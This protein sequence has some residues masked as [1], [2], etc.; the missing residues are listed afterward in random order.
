MSKA[1][2]EA[3]Y[4]SDIQAFFFDSGPVTFT[5]DAPT[6]GAD[7]S[8]SEIDYEAEQENEEDDEEN[9]SDDSDDSANNDSNAAWEDED[10]KRL[11]ISLT[12]TNITKK[13]RNDEEED[14]I[15]GAEYTRRLRKQ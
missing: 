5:M 10:D 2:V 9:D 14:V 12:A 1:L 11:K 8:D 13:L 4:S 6:L 7:G 3:A 15:D